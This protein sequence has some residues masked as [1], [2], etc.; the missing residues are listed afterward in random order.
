MAGKGE[1]TRQAVLDAATACFGRDGYRAT[2]VTRVARE[3]GVGP[4]VPYTY[5]PGK[6]ALFLAAVDEDVARLLE[7]SV[8]GLIA[9]APVD[10]PEQLLASLVAGVEHHPLAGRLL[11]GLEPEWTVRA[12]QVPALEQVRKL[13][14]ERLSTD[15]AAGLVR[16]DIDPDVAA[17]GLTALVMSLLMAVVQLGAEVGAT[18]F[19]DV[20]AVLR[21]SIDAPG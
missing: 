14:A 12:L 7:R 5:Y 11:A 21:A 15:Q 4:T 18:Y 9:E 10:W 6:E 3:A 8:D 19:D 13:A 20:A 1:Q 17:R 16:T 2:S